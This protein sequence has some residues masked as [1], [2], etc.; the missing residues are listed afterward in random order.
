MLSLQDYRDAQADNVSSTD[1]VE[2]SFADLKNKVIEKIRE[3]CLNTSLEKED[4][5]KIVSEVVTDYITFAKP[6][7][8]GYVV[9]GQ[10]K[11][12]TLISDMINSITSWGKLTIFT[13]RAD[14]RELQI[15][16]PSIFVDTKTGYDL[17][18]DPLTNKVIKFDNP[19]EALDFIKNTLN[20]SGE[21]MSE[22]EPLVNASS[23][24]GYR[25]SCTHS[26]IYPPHPDEPT[27]KW[28]TATYRKV[29]GGALTRDDFLSNGTACEEQL[30]FIEFTFQALIGMVFVGTTGCGKTTLMDLGLRRVDNK[31]RIICIQQPSEYNYRNMIDGVMCNNAVYWEVD[32]QANP[33]KNRSATQ[34]N[35][36]THSLRNNATALMLGECRNDEDFCSMAR[37]I[38]AGSEVYTSLHSFSIAGT[39]DRVA[40]EL[41]SGMHLDMEVAREQACKY[42]RTVTLCDR[43]GDKSRK[44]MGQA[45]IV[46]YDRNTKSYIINYLFEF[47]LVDSVKRLGEDGRPNGLSWNVGF[48]V[49]R[50]NPSEQYIRSLIKTGFTRKELKWL[51][52]IPN[53]TV[54]KE[55]NYDKLDED[56]I[57]EYDD[58]VK[59]LP[60]SLRGFKHREP[61]G[62]IGVQV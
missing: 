35:L 62:R 54:L 23:I 18:R 47:V 49:K 1:R 44:I 13:E 5:K 30:K 25:I 51:L 61:S 2:I 40:L 11:I 42:L 56:Y 60:N 33:K 9:D 3:A 7:C 21:R 29:G 24:E 55:I 36:V 14:M 37:A 48:F 41:V 8:D 22:E 15:N 12:K 53:G 28:P 10:L 45:E 43:L 59:P 19:T 38:N 34:N 58:D 26:C 52:D 57:V 17:L 4:F 31:D 39:I 32:P 16:G 46:G 20:F 6:Y 50:N 27:L